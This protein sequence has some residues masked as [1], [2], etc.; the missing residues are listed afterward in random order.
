MSEAAELACSGDAVDDGNEVFS[1]VE[2]GDDDDDDEAEA[3]EN[4][5]NL[6]KLYA[7]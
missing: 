6:A 7:W 1:E 5:E 2:F 3:A 4:V